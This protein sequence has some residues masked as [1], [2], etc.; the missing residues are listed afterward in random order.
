ME[1]KMTTHVS[2][3]KRLLAISA[4]AAISSVV[5]AGAAMAA[6]PNAPPSILVFNQKLSGTSVSIDYANIP[7]N[8]YVV[9]Y[10]ADGEGKRTGELLG[11][12]PVQAGSHMDLK[13]E[14]KA[15]PK[16][17]SALWASLYKDK[18]GKEGF[19]ATVD[20]PVWKQLPMQN[21]FNIE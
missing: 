8:G 11:S 19:N 5:L 4:A 7:T 21:A 12:L 18:D 1:D 13:V 6:V 9:I 3:S 14:L 2:N 20:Q 17:G 15:A 10:A 16:T